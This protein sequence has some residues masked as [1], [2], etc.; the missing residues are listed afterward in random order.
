[1]EEKRK[2]PR[3]DMNAKIRFR[4][5]EDEKSLQDGFV[6]DISAE[7]FCFGC[8]EMLSPGDIVQV[9]VVEDYLPDSPLYVKGQVVWTKDN[10]E[11]KNDPA[12]PKF[13]TGIKILG[14]RDT[15]EAR[16]TMYYCERMISELK[17]YYHL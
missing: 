4:K 12:K 10:P 15:D 11:A 7:G 14:I 3:F 9:E 13:L 8:E 16:F 17:K 6:K 2:Y 1:M 5:V